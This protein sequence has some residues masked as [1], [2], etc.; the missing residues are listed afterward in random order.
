MITSNPS[1]VAG[2]PSN[3]HVTSDKVSCGID[4][5]R[6]CGVSAKCC[7]IEFPQQCRI[8]IL[9]RLVFQSLMKSERVPFRHL[10]ADVYTRLSQNMLIMSFVLNIVDVTGISSFSIRRFVLFSAVPFM[11]VNQSCH[12]VQR[13]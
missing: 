3:F 6:S 12:P 5:I 10:L 8:S 9:Y 4:S 11:L 13:M 2:L 7:V 1:T